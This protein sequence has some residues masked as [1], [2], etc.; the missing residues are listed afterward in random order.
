MFVEEVLDKLNLNGNTSFVVTVTGDKGGVV[1]GVKTVLLSA[2]NQIVVRVKSGDVT[3]DG[4]G[5]SLKQ[6]GGGDAYI[7]GEIARI[8]IKNFKK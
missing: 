7:A 4:E 2:P 5:L 3:I 6:M 8:E 1:S